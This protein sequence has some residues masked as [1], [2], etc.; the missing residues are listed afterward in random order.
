MSSMDEEWRPLPGHDG[1]DVSS[2]GRVRSWRSLNGRGGLKDSPHFLRPYV[3]EF[4]PS[5]IPYERIS[6]RKARKLNVAFVHHLIAAVFI[7]ERPPGF[8]VRHLNGNSLDNRIEN[9]AYGTY[10]DNMMDAMRHG[11]LLVGARS[12][13]SVVNEY[14]V[15]FIRSDDIHTLE[16]ISKA[17]GISVSQVF[18][19]KQNYSWSHHMT[20][21]VRRKR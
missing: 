18:R 14:D 16:W 21:S 9:I 15:A 6:L 20:K 1:Y 8:V 10:A 13:M 17:F 2:L 12:P 11:T 19:I 3:A 7:G 5:K 4:G